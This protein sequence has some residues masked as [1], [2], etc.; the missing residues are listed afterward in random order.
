M[1]VT[2]QMLLACMYEIGEIGAG[3]QL[4]VRLGDVYRHGNDRHLGIPR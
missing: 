1:K 4:G 2:S 3:H